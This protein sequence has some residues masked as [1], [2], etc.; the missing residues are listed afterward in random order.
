MDTSDAS[1]ADR[2]YAANIRNNA[3][4]VAITNLARQGFKTFMP[5]RLKTVRHAR[6]LR[7]SVAPLFPGYLFIRLDLSRDRWRSVNSTYGVVSLIMAGPEPLP[8][9]Q[10]IVEAFIL[11]S[12][13]S[14]IVC[15]DRELQLG[16]RVKLL[17]GPFAEQIGTLERL[18][19]RGRVQVLLEMM[20][21]VIRVVS[22]SRQVRP[23]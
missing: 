20:G 15:F 7:T 2:W 22:D 19:D 12:S 11:M 23:V 5:L 1:A 10:G 18:D 17:S 14:S 3:A 8:V 9:P 21:A 13:E 6:Q 4:R 16:Q